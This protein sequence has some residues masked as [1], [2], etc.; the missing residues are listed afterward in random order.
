ME[1][2]LHDLR[3][4]ETVVPFGV[5][6][7]VDVNRASL[8]AADTSWWGRG[9]AHEIHC[10]RLSR[11]LGF[12][13]LLEA[14]SH[15]GPGSK[16]TKN[17]TYWRFPQW[18]FCERCDRVSQF[19]GKKKG[20]WVNEC[21]HCG[22]ALIPMRY[23]A[24]CKGGSHIQDIPWGLWIHRAHDEGTS[25]AAEECRDR[26][27]LRLIR[28]A[29]A[30]EG[31]Q[32]LRVKCTAC[33]RSRSLAELVSPGMLKRDGIKCSGRQPWQLEP[34]AA[35]SFDL[36]AVQRGAT[37][38]YMAEQITALDIPEA[39]P[40]S[41][42]RREEV[43][44]HGFFAKL[45]DERQGP[46]AEMITEMIADDLQLT[47][48]D[49]LS[50]VSDTSDP[51]TSGALAQDLKSGEWA[52][53][54]E[55]MRPAGRDSAEG[56]FVVDSWIWDEQSTNGVATGVLAGIGQV[57]KVREVRALTGFRRHSPESALIS[58]DLG[59][60]S[61][62]SFPSIELFGEGVFLKL[63]ETHVAEW[64]KRSDV[65]QRCEL[66]VSRY[67][68][69]PWAGRLEFPEPRYV[70]LHTVA[71]LLIRRLAFESG[72]ASAALRERIYANSDRENNT[73]GIL[74]YTASGDA[75]G[76]LGG[77]VRLGSPEKFAPLLAAA[78]YDG[79]YCSNDPVCREHANQSGS[80]LNL[81]AC[82]GCA[83]ISETS[84]ESSNRLLDRQL[85]LGGPG[86]Q[87]LF[88]E[89]VRRAPRD[90]RH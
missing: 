64:E 47:V 67:Q 53:F 20:Q 7:I 41:V 8:I 27:S 50:V 28:D 87:G 19:T 13:R 85:A 55:K 73:A 40:V 43:L 18:R 74:I 34:A 65:R 42:K 75:Q 81:S 25:E 76:T 88:Q 57:R 54:E 48:E 82:H 86:L 72:Y 33:R 89:A 52:A 59:S 49:V 61:T 24:V 1:P 6:S 90:A 46:R 11:R 12:G 56:D 26:A 5:G 70:A 79:D 83:L 31:L 68:N 63:T 10:E 37:G 84:C 22:G 21:R 32:S 17:L 35:C 60:D 80:H 2:I 15:A 58:S 3:L 77:L 23:V 38:N 45:A 14:P 16:T 30:G 9:D 29:G 4:S 69:T 39:I 62:K 44:G 51:P 71:H 66:L 78:F 36:V